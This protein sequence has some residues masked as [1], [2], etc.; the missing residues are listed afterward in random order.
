VKEL[1]IYDLDG[2]LVD[3]RT[4][5]VLGVRHMLAEMGA[6][7][8]ETEAIES[9]VG[10]G[11]HHLV[12]SCL[13]T[14][15]EARVRKGAEIFRSHYSEHMLDHTRLYPHA[16]EV[17]DF[18]RD[19]SQAVV[20]NKPDPFATEMLQALGVAGYFVR[21]IAGNSG[22]AQK[23]DPAGIAALRAERKT[24]PEAVLLVG[25]S[26]IDIE[27]GRRAGVETAIIHHGFNRPHELESGRPDHL[28]PDLQHFLELARR[29]G[30]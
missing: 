22:V 21:I 14:G 26:L 15:D 17:L 10:K 8:L 3:T 25:D 9:F 13:G 11:L 6:E 23:P 29:K 18:F 27:T 2:T 16:R 30:W 28:C 7:P 19:R 1:I 24:R 5:I 20:T 12:R 4:D